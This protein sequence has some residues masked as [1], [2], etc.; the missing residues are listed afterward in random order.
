MASKG[1]AVIAPERKVELLE[2]AALKPYERNARTHSA[3]QVAQI[4]ASIRE[5]GWTNPIFV[6]EN[7]V[8]LAGHGRRLAA[9]ELG[10][11][12]VPCIVAHGWTAAQK[13]AYVLADN[14][15][16]EQ[17]GW[18]KSQLRF[19]LDALMGLGFNLDLTGFSAIDVRGLLAGVDGNTDPDDVPPPPKDPVSR[20]GDVWLLGDHRIICGDSTNAETVARLLAGAAPHLM[21]T[22]PPYGVNYDASWRLKAGV[23]KAHQK[24][25]EGKVLNDD[26]A[27]W[28]EAWALF[29]GAVAYVWHGGLHSHTV[30]DSLI[31]C[32]F[33]MRSQIIWSKSSL[34]MGRGNYHWQHEPCWYAVRRGRTAHYVGDRKQSSVWEIESMHATQGNVDDGVTFD[35]LLPAAA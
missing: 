29:P 1:K 32:E 21:V 12:K 20:P 26:R 2:L 5:W 14:R 22:D 11:K 4:V 28:R 10:L 16:A 31:A 35:A 33:E 24:R 8:I 25:A 30:A 15:L 23:N 18:D 3:E 6:D 34:V 19:E 27:D 9:L 13:R 7:M 17:A